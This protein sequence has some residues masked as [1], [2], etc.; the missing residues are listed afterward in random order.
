MTEKL[1]W[2]INK[3]R[4]RLRGF[5][6]ELPLYSIEV[7]ESPD[8]KSLDEFSLPQVVAY[9][10]PRWERVCVHQGFNPDGGAVESLETTQ[11]PAEIS[12]RFYGCSDFIRTETDVQKYMIEL[13]DLAN[14]DFAFRIKHVEPESKTI[15]SKGGGRE[16]D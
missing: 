11:S 9:S 7:A 3:E 6:R 4:T 2:K 1:T 13:R 10:E 15:E 12:P 14:I 8:P 16:N 5:Y